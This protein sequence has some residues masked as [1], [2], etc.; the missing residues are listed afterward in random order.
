VLPG[1]CQD[2]PGNSLAFDASHF[3]LLDGP[4]LS[5]Y[6]EVLESGQLAATDL[7]LL[8]TVVNEFKDAASSRESNRL[9][10]LLHSPDLRCATL[11]NANFSQTHEPPHYVD[12]GSGRKQQEPTE[13]HAARCV[14]SAAMWYAKHLKQQQ[15]SNP[16]T[17]VVVMESAALSPADPDLIEARRVGVQVVSCLEYLDCWCKSSLD[18]NAFSSLQESVERLGTAYRDRQA[19]ELHMGG[20]PTATDFRPHLSESQLAIALANGKIQVG[21]CDEMPSAVLSA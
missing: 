7:I 5:M 17:I 18:E 10:S 1:S 8:Q 6:L 4:A 11:S 12:G 13:R 19:K 20:L 3:L 9:R 2:I 14:L 15:L 16:P 21:W